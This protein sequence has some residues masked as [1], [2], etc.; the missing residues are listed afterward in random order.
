VKVLAGIVCVTAVM[1]VPA[2]AQQGTPQNPAVAVTQ[3][4]DQFV[5]ATMER[6][7]EVATFLGVPNAQH[8]RVFDNSP[9]AKAAWDQQVD[10]FQS[11]LRAINKGG[12]AGRPELITYGFLEQA[13]SEEIGTRPCS[14]ELW[15]VDQMNGWQ[16]SV[17]AYL[18][19][20]PVATDADRKAALERLAQYPRSIDREIATL[21]RGL[22][23]GY[24][25]PRVSV[26][27]V[28]AQIE[29]LATSDPAKSPFATPAARSEDAAF[30]RAV[31]ETIAKQ[32]NPA[33]A[34]YRSFLDEYLTVARTSVGVA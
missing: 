8:A 32:L 24:S 34:R 5:A 19:R 28:V 33:L 7:P 20:Q 10:S 15:N 29:S 4:A 30:K 27:R 21:Q 16:V 17:P 3:L 31:A 6:W 18:Q 12:L 11:S 1:S 9:E 13:I 2:R 23:A 26:E 14:A 22:A 25:A